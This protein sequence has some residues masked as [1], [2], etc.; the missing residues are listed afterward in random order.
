M[1]RKQILLKQKLQGVVTLRTMLLMLTGSLL[2]ALLIAVFFTSYGYFRDYVSGQ[3]AGHA[4]DG[5]TAIG[6]SLSNA[7]DGRDPVASA[8]LIDSVFDSGRYLSI[9]YLNHQDEQIAGRAMTLNEVAVPAWFRHFADLPLPVAE[10]EV[11][12]GWSRLGTVQVISHPGRA[13]ED[14][15]RITVGLT[16]G[17]SVIGG[18]GLFAVFLLLRRTLRPLQTLEDQARA[19]GQ[20]DFR[21]RVFVKSTREI[22]QVTDAMNR[23]A[24]DLGQLFEGQAK[25]IQ[26]LRRV[27]NEDSVTGLASRSAFDQRLKVE[28]ESE[29]KAAHGV[30]ML[31]QLADLSGYN[32]AYGRSEADRLLH[33]VGVRIG[34]FVMQHANAFAGRRTGAEFAIFLPGVMPADASVWCRQLVNDIDGVYSD[35]ASPMDTAV[36]AGL[37]GTLAGLGA[38]D[39]M[40]AADEA[41]RKAQS[42]GDTGC[43][44]ADP[45]KDDHLN[46]ETWRMIISEAIRGETLSLWFQPMVN[47]DRL[48]PIYHQVFSRIDTAEGSLKAGT[49]VPMAERFGLIAGI[50]RLL[51]QRVLDRLKDC[52]DEPLAISLGNA[53]VASEEFRADLLDQLQQ[54]GSLARNLWVGISEQSVNHHRTSVGLLVRALGRLGVPVLVDRFGVGGVPFSYLRNLRFQ[55][56]RIDNSFIHDIDTHED[57]RFYIESVVAIAHSR[58]V[59]VFATGVETASEYSVLC[60]LGIDGAMG[61][62]LG[63]P[64]AADNQPT[65][66]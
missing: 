40:A 33:E 55:A 61:Y 28:V 42:A 29:E 56:V 17:T 11:V 37:T 16:T 54:A 20:R 14:L 45:D 46:L 44:L 25:L 57:N 62:H 6:L 19:L 5:A 12:R 24:D 8:S 47:E 53:S 22:N 27:N 32:Q 38:S 21:K 58:G 13:Y 26:H 66:D 18:I 15:W 9:S 48:M 49:F 23:M 51:V 64:F 43:H 52:P 59:K 1:A 50:D 65:G 30:L 36:H 39:L 41:L 10:A 2:V 31:V 60:K 3:L 35:L 63:R 34:D 4:R 7:I